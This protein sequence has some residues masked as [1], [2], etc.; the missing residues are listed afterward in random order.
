MCGLTGFV[1]SGGIDALR[2]MNAVLAHRGPDDDGVWCDQERGVFL[3]HR[4]LSIVDIAGGHQ[5][6]WTEDGELG[7]VFN[8]EIYNQGEL[9]R[10]LTARGYVFRT[11]GSDTEVLLHGYR[12][13]GASLPER[14]NGMWAF[15]IYDRR[16]ERLFC[17]RDRFGKKPF[18]YTVR[19]GEFVFASELSALVLHPSV[20]PTVSRRSLQKYF[21]YG[22]I[23]APH[24]LYE[25]VYKLPGGHS[26]TF[27]VQSRE[28]SIQK[29]WDF[30]IE[31]YERIPANPEREWGEQL[32]SLL[33]DAV[34]RRLMSDVP[35]GF[36]LSGGIDSSS[37][38]ALAAR[39]MDP[40]RVQTF[41]IGFDE[42]SFDESA[43]AARMASELGASHHCEMLSIEKAAALLPQIAARLDEPMG[44]AS[45]LPTYLLCQHTR[46]HATVA[47][48]GD[49]A[50][51]LFAG[52]DPFRALRA[53]EMY[54]R[55]VPRPLHIAVRLLLG[56]VLPVSH[57]NMS[58]DFKIKRTLRGLSHRP[59]LWCPV[60]M[61][62]LDA[63]ELSDAFAE[64]VDVEEVYA[65][66]IE[67]WDACQQ[68]NLVDRVL[69]FYTKLYLQDDILVK[70]DR[71]SMMHSL[72]VRAPYLDADLVDFVR[73]IPH[74]FKYRR[75]ETKYLLR[76]ALADVLP[77]WVFERPKK[78]FGIPVAR[79]IADG[80]LEIDPKAV[81]GIRP[82][83]VEARL[84]SHLARR[85]DERAFLWSYWLCQTHGAL[86]QTHGALCQ[87]HG[88]LCR[89]H[90]GAAA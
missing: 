76:R 19:N 84:R 17:S 2:R 27:S 73:R 43:Y 74:T 50:D 41:S 20:S 14:L 7:V 5:P 48:G 58:L 44:D 66:A 23:P 31:P 86:C 33:D 13:F 85:V 83:F 40:A 75:G 52:Y 22:Y 49:G 53:A 56:R 90:G 28:L 37:I 64:P 9:R 46:A 60:W 11:S 77:A 67:Q 4:R 34:K 89:T 6:M 70:V 59:Q 16:T 71:A 29:Y 72:E 24:S 68:P 57:T 1:G 26:L 12:E 8:G 42:A 69:Q 51:E 36:F 21:A 55:L 65:E 15:V 81:P 25:G 61:G 3:G 79:W 35:L 87:T 54:G 88:A 30:V 32:L 82:E 38:V 63:A 45:L 80:L 10:E 18:F 62:P 39:H 78:G 47:L